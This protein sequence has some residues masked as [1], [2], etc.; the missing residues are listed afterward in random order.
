[1]ITNFKNLD[2]YIEELTTLLEEPYKVY[3]ETKNFSD[4]KYIFSNILKVKIPELNYSNR[5]VGF[6]NIKNYNSLVSP[7]ISVDQQSKQLI[8][9]LI[10]IKTSSLLFLK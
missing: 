3:K 1:M 7:I 9:S 2:T 5:K 6:K 8:C 4:S 10:I